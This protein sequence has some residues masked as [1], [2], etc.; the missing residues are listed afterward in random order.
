MLAATPP[1]GATATTL[2]KQAY[3]QRHVTIA[4]AGHYASAY[5][6]L[7]RHAA[8]CRRFAGC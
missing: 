7:P 5:V 1:L 3:K 2:T 8:D 6:T 4:I